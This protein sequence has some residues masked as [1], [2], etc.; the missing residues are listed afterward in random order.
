[1][2]IKCKVQE[3]FRADQFILVHEPF[4]KA[5]F[6]FKSLKSCDES[7]TNKGQRQRESEFIMADSSEFSR[8]CVELLIEFVC[9]NSTPIPSTTEMRYELSYVTND[10]LRSFLEREILSMNLNYERVM[11]YPNPTLV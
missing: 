10:V 11:Y 5:M 4:F 8:D 9:K 2:I 7:D 6:E 1:V 3:L